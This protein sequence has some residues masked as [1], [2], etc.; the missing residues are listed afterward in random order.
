MIS[1]ALTARCFKGIGNV[2]IAVPKSPN[3]LLNQRKVVLYIA[4]IAIRGIVLPAAVF[5]QAV[6]PERK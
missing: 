6:G 1:R 4:G 2:P 5:K 3:S